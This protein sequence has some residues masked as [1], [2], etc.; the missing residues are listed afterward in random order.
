RSTNGGSFSQIATTGTNVTTYNDTSVS[1]GNTYNYRVRATNSAGDSGYSNTASATTPGSTSTT[2]I[3]AP[4]SVWK[5]ID[6]GLA[7]G[8]NWHAVNFDD[9]AWKSGPANSATATATKPPSSAT[10]PTP[11]T[12]TSPPT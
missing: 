9:S 1:A 6:N 3:I 11:T 5:Y 7:Q 10:A 8:S 4:A 2:T 12:S